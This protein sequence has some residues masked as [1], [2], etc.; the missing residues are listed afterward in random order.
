MGIDRLAERLTDK[1]RIGWT[2]ALAERLGLQD[3]AAVRARLA[4]Q[5]SEGRRH[6][7]VYLLGAYVVDDTDFWGD[8]EIY[9]WSIPALVDHEGRTRPNPLNGLPTGEPPHK[10]GSLEWMT[11]LS[12]AQPPLLAVIPPDSSLASCVLRIAF[13]DD[14]GAAADLPAALTAGLEAFASLS[15]QP[16]TGAEQ[17]VIPVRDAIW[18][19]LKADE[20]DILIDQ[21]IILRRGETMHFGTG[22]IGSVVNAMARVYYFVRDEGRTQQFGPI[23]LHKGQVE[24]V[25]FDAPLKG[26]GR[27]ALFSRGAEVSCSAFGDLDTDRPFMNRIIETRHEGGLDHGFNV[28]G[29]GPAKFMA[30]YTPPA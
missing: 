1:H 10:V 21:D 22:M 9:W 16:L 12:L 19:S 3:P 2:E 25:K 11:S 13:Y 5:A 6:L 24:T 8:G 17:V 26:G 18:K 28:S 30:F 15:D 4:A 23:A 27:L 7:G 29:T 20:D 14:D